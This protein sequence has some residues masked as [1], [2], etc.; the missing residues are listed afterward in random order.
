MSLTRFACIG[1]LS[2]SKRLRTS[3]R[4]QRTFSVNIAAAWQL[5]TWDEA[6][7][8]DHIAKFESNGVLGCVIW[9]GLLYDYLRVLY[10]N[11]AE[12]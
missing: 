5:T 10:P 6:D 8:K 2:E 12:V 4:V 7:A 3:T 1:V 9:I 11:S